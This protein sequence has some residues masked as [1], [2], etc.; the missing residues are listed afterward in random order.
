MWCLISLSTWNNR[1]HF[2]LHFFDYYEGCFS[3][4][5]W[6]FKIFFFNLQIHQE[7]IAQA[8]K[9][10]PNV[11]S[12]CS[13][14]APLPIAIL[15]AELPG[16]QPECNLVELFSAFNMLLL[17][18]LCVCLCVCVLYIKGFREYAGPSGSGPGL[19]GHEQWVSSLFTCICS[20]RH[21]ELTKLWTFELL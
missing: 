9:I 18:L 6:K 13:L 17:L 11:P 21:W 12:L 20:V 14:V 7:Q 15:S 5:L 16:N 3:F 1:S 19:A 2:D 4:I 8:L 10:K